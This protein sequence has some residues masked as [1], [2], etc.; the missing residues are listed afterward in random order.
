MKR[1]SSTDVNLV[2]EFSEDGAIDMAKEHCR[3]NNRV[4]RI[5]DSDRQSNTMS[6]VCQRGTAASLYITKQDQRPRQM[7]TQ[8][9][10]A[11]ITSRAPRSS[12]SSAPQPR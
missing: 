8:L 1:K 2:T 3:E 10:H 12:R 11:R 9:D 5:T 7:R 4:A 6:F